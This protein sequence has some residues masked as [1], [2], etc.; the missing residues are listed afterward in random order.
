MG[1]TSDLFGI[2][3]SA[4]VGYQRT[5][6]TTSHNISNV[7]N[8]N[9]SRQR[10]DLTTNPA[11]R[12]GAGFI[13]AGMRAI[14]V[15]RQY[16]EFLTE[17]SRQ[18]SS[19][20][21]R[22][23]VFYNYSGQI[24][25]LLADPAAGLMP[26][27]ESFF[28]A[29]HDVSNDPTSVPTRSVMIEEAD[30]M[31]DRFHYMK[32]RIDD[33]ANHVNRE[34]EQ[35][36]GEIN[37]LAMN[38]SELNKD[39]VY[40][41]GASGGQPPNDLL[42][43]RDTALADL[44]KLVDISTYTSDDGVINVFMGNGQNL[45]VGFGTQQIKVVGNVYDRNVQEVTYQGSDV[46][47][48]ELLTGGKLGGLFNVRDD[49][50]FSAGRELG[51]IGISIAETF[52]EQHRQGMDING[53][54]GLDFF[55]PTAVSSANTGGAQVLADGYHNDPLTDAT[56]SLR[57]T[58]IANLTTS[59]YK[60]NFDGSEF[61]LT[62]LSD[63]RQIGAAIPSGG[64]PETLDFSSEGFELTLDGTSIA[65]GDTF[66]IRPTF[67][68]AADI[69]VSQ[70]QPARIAAAAP[71]RID[72]ASSANG[73]LTNNGEAVVSPGTLSNLNPNGLDPAPTL[74]DA[75][76]V[77]SGG[78]NEI[79]MSYVAASGGFE[80][81]PGSAVTSDN[82]ILYNPATDSGNTYTVTIDGFGE[83]TF[84]VSGTPVDGDSFSLRDNALD[85]NGNPP[86]GGIGDA[87]NAL[88]LANLQTDPTMG[89]A[90]GLTDFQGAY[91]SMV[92]DVGI[93]THQAEVNLDARERLLDKAEEERQEV[94]GVNL[95]EEAANLIRYQQAYQAA[96]QV[97]SVG[98]D[99]IQTLLGATGR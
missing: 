38:I 99:V 63:N 87:R 42:D 93:R 70:R 30:A 25:D 44:A 4:L 35:T 24:D 98:R 73:V 14:S 5:L 78:G 20:K 26:A 55:Y 12:S 45:V 65:E 88:S 59:D 84:T 97:L 90:V 96:A 69:N 56:G 67:N 68:G 10:V 79:S 72:Q 57:F 50:V 9:Y 33:L 92:A 16:D 76:A 3:T 51:R 52:N 43:Q 23:E 29:V 66:L 86:L 61:T 36:V 94:S 95:D 81:F 15:T 49:V 64:F 2:G 47:V 22:L 31:A 8:E 83:L 7:Q 85:N 53:A 80:F 91:S 21:E 41:R 34:I 32:G 48:T 62:R 1:T 74:S 19:E 13:G 75:L 17:T 39:I 18:H 28:N 54:I 11:S 71:L 46:P 89:G 27:I 40:Q 37:A 82:P 58:N 60:L 6:A 77:S